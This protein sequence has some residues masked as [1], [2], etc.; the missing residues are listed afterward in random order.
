MASWG[1]IIALCG[2]KYDM[3]NNCMSFKPAINEENFTTFWSTGKAWGS[4]TQKFNIAT[5]KYD[6]YVKVLYGSLEG[7]TVKA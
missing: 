4:Y 5:G 1:V 2:F 3:V 7:K 6:A